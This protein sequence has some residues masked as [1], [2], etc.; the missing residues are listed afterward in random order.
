MT[1]L[2]LFNFY[3]ILML[4]LSFK[5]LK[6]LKFGWSLETF[7][8]FLII[9]FYVFIPITMIVYDYLIFEEY[10]VP[11]LKVSYNDKKYYSYI[12]FFSVLIFLTFFYIGKISVSNKSYIIKEIKIKT[13]SVGGKNISILILL[14]YF[15]SFISFISLI[16]YVSQFGSIQN[17]IAYSNFVRSG[18]GDDVFVSTKYV[19]VKRFIYFSL[20]SI[21]IYF[22]INNK[23]IINFFTLLLVP[24]IVTIFSQIFLFSGK[25]GILT[26]LIIIIFFYSVKNKKPYL[27][28]LIIFAL[29]LSIILPLLDYLF[30][31]KTNYY[32]KEFSNN[33]EFITFLGYFSF[34]QVSLQFAINNNY[35][36]LGITDFIYGLKGTIL[37]FSSFEDWKTDSMLL[38]T[39]YFY[40]NDNRP[41]VPPGIIAFSFYSFGII[42]V[43][44]VGFISGIL[45][46]KIDIIFKNILIHNNQFA[47]FYAFAISLVF[48]AVRTG[49]P[50]FNF[51]HSL[52]ITFIL[53]LVI[54]FTIIKKVKSSD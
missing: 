30:L 4:T 21:L 38:N 39:K 34:P 29:S 49:L 26:L 28:I 11:D 18:H 7:F 33:F 15:F 14:A 20:L 23:K 8:L 47:I 9:L 10:L 50:K 17:A 48:T 13:F 36:Y 51:Y 16:L 31:L 1:E 32:D 44:I 22:F 19:F 37:P 45:I 42:G 53:T 3:I 25:Q 40:G 24:L 2:I 27:N 46:K 5:L 41:I 6:D 54:S 43:V 52:V 35:E 12:S